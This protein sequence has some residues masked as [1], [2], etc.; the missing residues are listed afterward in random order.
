MCERYVRFL[1][2]DARQGAFTQARGFIPV[3]SPAVP[4]CSNRPFSLKD[5]TA[6][7]LAFTALHWS[8]SLNPPPTT[9][10]GTWR[11]ICRPR[12]SYCL[13]ESLP[14]CAKRQRCSRGA[15]IIHKHLATLTTLYKP[16]IHTITNAALQLLHCPEADRTSPHGAPLTATVDPPPR[17]RRAAGRSRARGRAGAS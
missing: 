3:G 16:N 17:P 1:R 14:R 13:R 15:I 6:S 5:D 8:S 12:K 2:R 4:A 11:P 10:G 9:L 7:S